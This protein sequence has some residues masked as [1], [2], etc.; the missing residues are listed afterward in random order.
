MSILGFLEWLSATSGSVA[1][2]ESHYFFLAVLTVHV[3]TLLVFAG[4]AAIIDLRL[5][6]LA[7]RRVPTSQIVTQLVPWAAGGFIVMVTSGS[8]LF[9]SAP[10]ERFGNLFFRTKL[11]LLVLAGLN[12]F[13]FHKTVYGRVA[14]WDIDRVPPASARHAGG[15]GLALWAGII[16]LGRM[17]AYQDYWF[18]S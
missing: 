10:L 12:V 9:Y 14:D 1:L 15:V 8:L 2:R 5:L 4:M 6:G 17:M 18:D 7:M 3:L 13:V 11:A 16:V